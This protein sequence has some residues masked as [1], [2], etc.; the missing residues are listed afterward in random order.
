MICFRCGAPLSESDFCNAC[1]VDVRR[2]KKIVYAANSCYNDGLERACVRD[3]S[4]AEHSLKQCL[5]LNKNHIEARNLLGLVYFETGETAAA[6]TQ[7]VISK[8]ISATNNLADEY[9][10]RFQSNQSRVETMSTTLKK[11][12]K[13]LELAQGGSFDLSIIQL[14]KVLSMNPKYVQAHNLLALLYFE[15]GDFE[16]ARREIDRTL[17][18]DRGNIT[19]LRYLN[20]VNAHLGIPDDKNSKGIRI[21]DNPSAQVFK[22]GNET[23]IQPLNDREPLGLGAFIQ[24]GLG[25][26]IGLAIT[27]FLVVPAKERAAQEAANAELSAYGET[28]DEKNATISELESRVSALEQNNITLSDSLA[29]YEGSNGAVDANNYLISAAMAYIDPSQDATQ[30]SEYLELI[31]DDYVETSSSYEFKE[32]YTYL[33]NDIGDSVA[34]NYYDTGLSYFNN[35]DYTLAI[36]YLSKAYMYNANNDNALYYLA[37]SYYES[38]DIN[39]ATDKLNTLIES[40]PTSSLVD[41][42]RQ[43]LDEMS[44]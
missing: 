9:I 18:I 2:Y 1:G 7:W 23:L 11:F 12:N 31:G 32:L 27:Y 5:K 35:G 25:I 34:Q 15:R 16:K 30:V 41:K 22:S 4:G 42:A 13:G 6:L 17:D 40:F 20:E 33:L 28:I 29:Q 14:R 21:F 37:M 43:R 39:T 44:Y 26:L 24:I 38:G 10:D 8:N 19:A 36:S 3:L